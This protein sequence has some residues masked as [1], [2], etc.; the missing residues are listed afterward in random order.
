MK[1]VP[2]VLWIPQLSP[3]LC[4]TVINDQPQLRSE[5]APHAR[6]DSETSDGQE[7]CL[8]LISHCWWTGRSQSDLVEPGSKKTE[9]KPV[10]IWILIQSLKSFEST[11]RRGSVEMTRGGGSLLP[12][13]N[14]WPWNSRR[15]T[16]CYSSGAVLLINTAASMVLLLFPS[17]HAARYRPS[18]PPLCCYGNTHTEQSGRPMLRARCRGCCSD[19]RCISQHPPAWPGRWWGCRRWGCALGASDHCKKTQTL[20]YT[21][22]LKHTNRTGQT[23]FFLLSYIKEP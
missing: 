9:D 2:A 5:L 6:A 4:C 17:P 15:V 19:C 11:E 20:C 7:R 18:P 23:S 22:L 8:C 12:L 14:V 10:S 3:V 1:S 21:V 16:L 13:C